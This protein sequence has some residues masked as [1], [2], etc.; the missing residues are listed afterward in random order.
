MKKN[1]LNLLWI[2]RV[3]LLIALLVVFWWYYLETR[4]PNEICAIPCA[5]PSHA[6]Q[7]TIILTLL[8]L[9]IGISVIIKPHIDKT[10]RMIISV[11]LLISIFFFIYAS[12]GVVNCPN[13]GQCYLTNG[14]SCVAYRLNS[15]T[16]ELDLR[17]GNGLEHDIQINRIKCVRIDS[18]DEAG[19]QQSFDGQLQQPVMLQSHYLADVTGLST[20][21]KLYC[22]DKDGSIPVDTSLGTTYCFKLYVEYTDLV[23]GSSITASGTLVGRYEKVT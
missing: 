10:T 6:I 21:N 1:R 22:T 5:K 9:I 4:S 12:M 11:L 13:L 2:L 19:S 16:S 20:K 7:K 23:N 17:L 8:V 15:G 3:V 14:L 18:V